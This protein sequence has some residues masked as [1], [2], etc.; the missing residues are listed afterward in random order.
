MT[1][2]SAPKPAKP[3][4]RSRLPMLP[5]GRYSLS[6]LFFNFYLFVMGSFVLI[7]FFADI[8][9]NTALQGIT[10]DY[11]RRF[12]RGTILLIEEELN[13]HPA[14]EW[15]VT[16]K[17]LDDKFSYRLA[18]IKRTQLR[19]PESQLDR[20]DSGD[21]AID[22]IQDVMY[23]RL[24]R[25]PDLVLEVGPLS[26]D[27]NPEAKR[28]IPLELRI[29]LLTWSIIGVGFGVVAWL[30]L[31]PIW[32][33]LESIRE[34]A[35]SLAE[36]DFAARAPLPRTR[37]F[38]L[39]ARTL[40]GMAE[41]IQR[42]LATQKE[43]SSAISHELRTPIARLRFALDMLGETEERAERERLWAGMEA[44]LDELDT[45]IDSSLTYARLEREQ[46]APVLEPVAL[47]PWL[48]DQLAALRPLAGPLQLELDAPPARRPPAGGLRPQGDAL[49]PLQ[50]AAQRHQVRP[51]AHRRAPRV[52]HGQRLGAA[53]RGR[54][55]DRHPHRRTGAH[56][57]RL[58][59]PRPLPGSGHRRLRPGPG[60]RPPGDGGPRRQRQRR[61]IPG[62][63][64][65]PHPG[66]ARPVLPDRHG[67]MPGLNGGITNRHN[68]SPAVTPTA[69]NAHRCRRRPGPR[70][71]PGIPLPAPE[72]A[73]T[74]PA[75]R[76]L[77]AESFLARLNRAL[78]DYLGRLIF[79]A[80]IP[81][82]RLQPVRAAQPQKRSRRVF[83]TH[84]EW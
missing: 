33:D 52:G 81:A 55:R 4:I 34:T 51:P 22:N 26:P 6:R 11:A 80:P 10:D 43:M 84:G 57:H 68:S 66:L 70:L 18:L 29:R 71:A 62:R 40:N 47:R 5:R 79:P 63:R 12:M 38:A 50:P 48:E 24:T 19:L 49:R 14:E 35:K 23:H 7:A 8:V 16:L 64:R 37:T 73:M 41:R 83:A 65:P 20:L 72:Y 9:I 54:R 25:H 45:L 15:P 58:H 76:T 61:R 13:R 21:I 53:A 1:A 59:P 46:P 30:W 3:R 67:R 28:A 2:A 60:H 56:L 44:D 17:R 31:R 77:R 78:G 32:R 39:L 75:R 42:Q 36:G 74:H 82:L 69:T 27:R